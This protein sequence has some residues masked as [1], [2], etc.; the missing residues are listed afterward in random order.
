MVTAASTRWRTTLMTAISSR[1]SEVDLAAGIAY[2]LKA[3]GSRAG[4]EDHLYS[5][6]NAVG[7]D[8]GDTLKGTDERNLLVGGRGGDAL[9]GRDGN[10]ILVG[11]HGLDHLY[12]GA[13]SDTASYNVDDGG[14]FDS[15]EVDLAAGRAYYLN[16]DMSRAGVEDHLYS[17]EN[18]VGYKD[19]DI[20]KGTDEQNLLIGDGGN[21]KLEGRGGA[22]ILGGGGGNDTIDGGA[23]IDTV[24]YAVD[25][26]DK[27]GFQGSSDGF[28]IN[29][30]TGATKR[31]N[32]LSHHEDT[33]ISIENAVGSDLRDRITG[34]DKDNTLQGGKGKDTLLGGGGNDTLSGGRDADHL[35]G[36]AGIDTVHYSLDPEDK[37][38]HASSGTGFDI[39]LAEGR[40]SLNDGSGTKLD[41]LVSIENAVGTGLD[42]KITGTDDAN[43]LSGGGGDDVV[44]GGKGNDTLAGGAGANTLKGGEGSDTASYSAK[45]N[46]IVADLSAGIRL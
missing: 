15:V 22:D 11:G 45:A 40:T 41:T 10:D 43:F 18:A 19:D 30:S 28:D 36:G 26:E 8:R 38:G 31:Y 39:N 27:N 5:I 25:A 44:H 34:T 46:G 20:L 7:S 16:A 4:T 24:N 12:G 14:S 9:H 3:D 21:D 13:G 17:I 35:D 33:L 42:D 23:G 32:N 37:D 1:R 6:E 29:L 2:Y